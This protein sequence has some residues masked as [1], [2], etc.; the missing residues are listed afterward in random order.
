M[1]TPTFVSSL[2]EAI[3]ISSQESFTH[4]WVH[5]VVLNLLCRILCLTSFRHF[6][7]PFF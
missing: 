4:S 3:L 1:R 2:L 5:C 7:E 6:Q